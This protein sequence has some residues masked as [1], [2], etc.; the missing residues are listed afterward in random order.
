MTV[1]RDEQWEIDGYLFGEWTEAVVKAGGGLDLGS[2]DS[3]TQDVDYPQADGGL[4]GR[5]YLSGPEIQFTLAIRDP[6]DVWARIAA[7]DAVWRN[8]AIRQTPGAMSTLRYAR[9]GKVYRFLG[10]GR[11]WAP[12]AA[13]VANNHL[14]QIACSFK[15]AAPEMYLEGDTAANNSLTL[16]LVE[17][18]SD[19]GWVWP[20]VWP[21]EL[22]ANSQAKTGQVI[23]GGTRPAPFKVVIHAP[24]TGTLSKISL[25]GP[26]WEITTSQTII[27]GQTITVDTALDTITMGGMSIAGTLTYDSDTNARLQPGSQII[28]FNATD[29]SNTA[30]AVVTWMDT[31]PA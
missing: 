3:R 31:Y 7:M 13:D 2:S 24:I 25:S 22:R 27:G 9:N 10:R 17:S 11:K 23:V 1:L 4:M 14:Q 28:Q 20:V 8:P 30:Y 19:G 26:G 29:P 15:C 6:D 16:Q 5:D 21:V 12:V 18:P